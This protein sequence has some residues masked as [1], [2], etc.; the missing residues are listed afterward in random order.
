M[1]TKRAPTQLG[2]LLRL[3]EAH[4]VTTYEDA[5]IKVAFGLRRHAQAEVVR[6]DSHPAP[7]ARPKKERPQVRVRD[8]LDLAINGISYDPDEGAEP[9]GEGN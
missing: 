8:A 1:P 9:P 5:T 7:G 3:L 6:E 4:G 2:A